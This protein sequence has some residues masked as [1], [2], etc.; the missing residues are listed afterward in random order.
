MVPALPQWIHLDPERERMSLFGHDPNM[1]RRAKERQ[2]K[3][4]LPY[5]NWPTTHFRLTFLS[6]CRINTIGTI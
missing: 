4:R 6:G 3:M 2:R 1:E 5:S